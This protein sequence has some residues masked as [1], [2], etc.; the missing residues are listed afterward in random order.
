M[1]QKGDSMDAE[2]AIVLLGNI[3]NYDV[4]RNERGAEKREAI[5]EAIDALEKQTPKRPLKTDEYYPY[6]GCPQCKH[7]VNA[8]QDHCERCGQAIDWSVS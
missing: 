6:Y 8:V 1:T 5:K 3:A 7:I 4:D 2:R